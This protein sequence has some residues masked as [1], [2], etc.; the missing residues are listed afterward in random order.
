QVRQAKA[1]FKT[2]RIVG[3]KSADRR[4]GARMYAAA[5]AAGL[6][7][8][9]RLISTQSNPALTRAFQSLLDDR[10]MPLV[11]RDLAGMALCALKE[12]DQRRQNQ[13]ESRSK[14]A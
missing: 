8:H 10:R 13:V 11:L 2:M 9:G 3:E 6:V 4:I 12:S 5:I 7:R 1:V 14:S